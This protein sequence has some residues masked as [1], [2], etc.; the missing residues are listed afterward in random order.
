LLAL[1][2]PGRIARHSLARGAAVFRQGDPARAVFVVEAGQIR[3]TRFLADGTQ[4]SLHLAVRGE[5]FAEPSLSA[6]RYH[7]DAIAEADSVVLALPKADLLAALG[8]DP[9]QSLKLAL[10]LAGQV[11]DLRARLE[12]RNIRSA[13]ERVLAWLHLHARGDPPTVRLTGSWTGIAGELG[14]SRE[15]VYRALAGLEML[16][17]ISRSSGQVCL[18]A[19]SG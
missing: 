9:A 17:K 1:L 2:P 19:K 15:A 8:A 6:E 3:L 5:S 11:R 18:Q 7:C 13:P 4:L 10:A 12:L 14:L 16:G